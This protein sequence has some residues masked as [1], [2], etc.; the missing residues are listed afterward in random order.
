MSD[1]QGAWKDIVIRNK[2]VEF[3][4]FDRAKTYFDR[5]FGFDVRLQP[6]KDYRKGFYCIYRAR[7]RF[8]EERVKP[9]FKYNDDYDWDA[10]MLWFEMTSPFEYS[11]DG[12]Y[13]N[14][15]WKK[16]YY[17]AEMRAPS[18]FDAVA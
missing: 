3:K 7:E 17:E 6:C 18:P 12:P 16:Q 13:M 2:L 10:L 14:M 8:E 4:D 15:E 9:G 11:F 5:A 1:A